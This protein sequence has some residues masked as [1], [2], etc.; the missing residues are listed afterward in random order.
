MISRLPLPAGARIALV[1]PSGPPHV[2]NTQAGIGLLRQWGYDPVPGTVV[3]AYL[4]GRAGLRELDFLAADDEARLGELEWGLNGDHDACWVV[5]GGHGLLRLVPRLRSSGVPRPV[6]GFSDVTALLWALQRRG[7]PDL[8]HAANVQTLPRLDEA[9]CQAVRGLLASGQNPPLSGHSY[10]A[11]EA[12]GQLCGGNLCVLAGL[13]GTPDALVCRDRILFLEDINEAPYRLDRLLCQLAASGALDGLRGV[14]FG[15]FAGCGDASTVL[16]HW[17]KRLGVPIVGE[18]SAGHCED[19]YPLLLNRTVAIDQ[20][21]MVWTP[22]S[23]T[24]G[25]GGASK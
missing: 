2:A 13:C 21:T 23:T 9:A 10:A 15:R 12:E 24:S 25:S 4:D 7:W 19:N 5:R 22:R 14:A 11:G 6:I 3:A 1:A 8:L 17:G 16:R 20:G 18:V